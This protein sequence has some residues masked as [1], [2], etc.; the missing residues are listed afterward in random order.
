MIGWESAVMV[1][2]TNDENDSRKISD[3]LIEIETVCKKCPIEE[4]ESCQIALK[5]R[6]TALETNHL[7]IAQSIGEIKTLLEKMDR[8][9]EAVYGP[10]NGNHA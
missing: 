9:W 3:R 2:L 4:V 10:K 6:I 8:K 5:S 1:R 7:N